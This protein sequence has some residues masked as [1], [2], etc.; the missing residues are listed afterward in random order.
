MTT[1]VN[2]ICPACAGTGERPGEDHG[3][4][5]C[6]MQ[7]HIRVD[8]DGNGAV[9]KGLQAWVDAA[10]LASTAEPYAHPE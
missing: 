5:V 8:R 4:Q 7:G 6:L 2:V 10:D 1:M 9:P 3:C